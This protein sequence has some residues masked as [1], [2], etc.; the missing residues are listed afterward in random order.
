MVATTLTI[1]HSALPRQEVPSDRCQHLRRPCKQVVSSS[2]KD[3]LPVELTV[4]GSAQDES[5]SD[6]SGRYLRWPRRLL[7][8]RPGFRT[9]WSVLFEYR[10]RSSGSG[11]NQAAR[12]SNVPASGANQRAPS[13][14]RR[15]SVRLIVAGSARPSDGISKPHVGP[16]PPQPKASGKL[17][18]QAA[19]TEELPPGCQRPCTSCAPPV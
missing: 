9:N 4:N 12:A 19:A 3:W 7:A 16:E 11:R 5:N 13:T 1:H 8:Y 10:P 18:D 14:A 2:R 15:R 17:E 6:G